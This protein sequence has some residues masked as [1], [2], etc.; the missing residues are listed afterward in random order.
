MRDIWG[1]A[2]E[3]DQRRVTCLTLSSFSSDD[4]PRELISCFNLAFFHD[5]LSGLPSLHLEMKPLASSPFF[6]IVATDDERKM[7]VTP[8]Q[9]HSLILFVSIVSRSLF[10]FTSLLSTCNS[11][12]IFIQPSYNISLLP[13]PSPTNYQ[14]W[15]P[16]ELFFC[17]SISLSNS[18]R[19]YFIGSPWFSIRLQTLFLINSY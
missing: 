13:H 7:R 1:I 6:S 19:T 16:L 10:A 17:L 3:L 11:F 5:W 8:E 2:F 18:V 12:V 14:I 15:L 4:R 9:V